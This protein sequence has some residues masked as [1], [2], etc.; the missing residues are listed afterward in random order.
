MRGEAAAPGKG[1]VVGRSFRLF[2]SLSFSRSQHDHLFNSGPRFRR[3]GVLAR[4]GS[5]RFNFSPVQRR[6][7]ELKLTAEPPA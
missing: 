2:G 7:K 4:P 5:L 1:D 3:E 6:V